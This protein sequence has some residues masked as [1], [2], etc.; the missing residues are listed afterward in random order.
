M[1]K[2]IRQNARTHPAVSV[3]DCVFSVSGWGGG[4]RKQS[5]NSEAAQ[6]H[7]TTNSSG[8]PNKEGVYVVM[9]LHLHVYYEYTRIQ[10]FMYVCV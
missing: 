2:P 1:N 7:K 10:L 6:M 8:V 4:T 3:D 5:L 9:G